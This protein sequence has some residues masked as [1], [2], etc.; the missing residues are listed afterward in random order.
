MPEQNICR[1][2]CTCDPKYTPETAASPRVPIITL[3]AS[4]TQ[5]VIRFWSAIGTDSAT[6]DL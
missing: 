2:V 3:S 5:K 1:S 6:R 4:V